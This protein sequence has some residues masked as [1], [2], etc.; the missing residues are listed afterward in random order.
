M[1]W[2]AVPVIDCGRAREPGVPKSLL[3]FAPGW[4]CMPVTELQWGAPKP[5]R[6]RGSAK[7]LLGKLSLRLRRRAGVCSG[8]GPF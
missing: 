1:N 2:R 3:G 7:E 4:S 8:L 5:R 6:N